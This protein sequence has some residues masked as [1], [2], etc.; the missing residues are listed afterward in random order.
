MDMGRGWGWA[1]L[2]DWD[3]HIYTTRV[4]WMASEELLYSTE[5]SA[6]SCVLTQM[7]GMGRGCGRQ[8]QEGRDVCVYI[9]DSLCYIAETNT[10]FKAT[11]LQ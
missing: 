10:T 1:E 9:A 8:A 6:R 3:C 5:S 7:A 2:G 4:K 11:I